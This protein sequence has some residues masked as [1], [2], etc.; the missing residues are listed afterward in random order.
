VTKI[1][2]KRILEVG[3]G[4]GRDSMKMRELGG[5][6]SLV[7][8]SAE[9]LHLIRQLVSNREV[10]LIMGDA[11]GCPF[12]DATFDVVFHQ[13]LL[14]HFPSPAPLLQ[15]NR[16]ILKKGG[17]LIIDVPQTFHIYTLMKHT[18]MAMG[19]WFGGWERQ[20][21]VASLTRLIRTSGFE[22]VHVYGDWSRPGVFYKIIRQLSMKFRMRLPMYPKYLGGITANFYELQNRLR[23]KRLFLYTVLSIGVIA[24]KV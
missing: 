10:A 17:L 5:D 20:F 2:G 21:T 1:A 13:G 12:G 19:F 11:R 18:L 9:S 6:L 14:E 4:T 23:R 8:Y 3:A 15:E 24:Q 7:D 22:P 16:R